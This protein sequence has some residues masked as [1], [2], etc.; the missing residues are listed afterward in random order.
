M[1]GTKKIRLVLFILY[2]FKKKMVLGVKKGYK[3]FLRNNS[4][5]CNKG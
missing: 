3:K 4:Y 2:L 5:G 1:G